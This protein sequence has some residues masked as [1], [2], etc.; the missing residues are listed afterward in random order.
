MAES[1]VTSKTEATNRVKH[2]AETP[3]LAFE[4]VVASE[5][6]PSGDRESY[7]GD[8]TE[9]L[10]ILEVGRQHSPNRVDWGGERYL[11]HIQL[12]ISSDVKETAGSIIR[13]GSKGVAIR[14]EL[15]GVD[16]VLMA[17][18]GLNSLTSTDVPKLCKGI[19]GSGDKD[20]GVCGVNAQA[21]DVSQMVRK[22]G[23]FGVLLDIPQHAGHVT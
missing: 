8:A 13:A 16:V 12:A 1:G 19:A 7:G 22:F 18:K 10:F 11:I 20:V 2:G 5:E 17:R 6:Q 3:Y 23:D 9:N 21:H 14:E 15:N 4:I